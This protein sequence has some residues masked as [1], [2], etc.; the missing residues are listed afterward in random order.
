MILHD[1]DQIE[2]Q[3]DKESGRV[4]ERNIREEEEGEK[5]SENGSMK[6]TK[7]KLG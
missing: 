5:R 2:S 7:H 3:R 6:R 1:K 4:A